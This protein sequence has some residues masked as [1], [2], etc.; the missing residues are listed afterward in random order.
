MH[1]PEFLGEA[2]KAHLDIDPADHEQVE[3]L[4]T[5]FANYPKP[6]LEQAKAA[7]AR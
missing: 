2:K 7:I 5:Q 6:V 3:Q 4:L 1:D